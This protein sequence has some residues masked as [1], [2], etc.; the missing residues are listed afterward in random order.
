[1]SAPRRAFSAPLA[2]ARPG[3]EEAM[4]KK[5][6]TPTPAFGAPKDNDQNRVSA[7][8]RGPAP[9]HD[10]H[11]LEKLVHFNRERIPEGEVAV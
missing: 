6:Q 9:M 7:S 8:A 4:A 2:D 1:V 11:L 10:I 3:K 5:P